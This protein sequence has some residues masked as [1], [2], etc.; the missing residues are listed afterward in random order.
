M[1]VLYETTAAKKELDKKLKKSPRKKKND[2][3]LTTEFFI[4][5][6]LVAAMIALMKRA[7]PPQ[8]AEFIITYQKCKYAI[9]LVA[10]L[11]HHLQDPTSDKLLQGFF[12]YLKEFTKRNKRLVNTQLQ[13][14]FSIL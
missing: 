13:I 6:C 2:R 11:G 5:K 4:L 9:N 3:K 1:R 10:K 12:V 8:E 7:E 14:T